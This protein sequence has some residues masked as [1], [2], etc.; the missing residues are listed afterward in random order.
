MSFRGLT[1]IL[2]LVSDF[3]CFVSGEARSGLCCCCVGTFFPRRRCTSE[4]VGCKREGKLLKINFPW[5]LKW[6]VFRLFP[7]VK[8][9]IGE[10]TR[11]R[12]MCNEFDATRSAELHD[13]SKLFGIELRTHNDLHVYKILLIIFEAKLS[14]QRNKCKLK[15]KN[16]RWREYCQCAN[17]SD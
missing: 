8:N 16:I 11:K 7:E 3:S 13:G 17:F 9:C 12:N 14:S 1:P 4:E 6:N 5:Y 10:V 2:A 15:S